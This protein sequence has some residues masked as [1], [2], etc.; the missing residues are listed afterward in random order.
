MHRRNFLLGLPALGTALVYGGTSDGSRSVRIKVDIGR[1][2]GTIPADFMG[3][4]YEISSVAR[5]GL[6]SAENHTYV[7]LVRTL[8]PRGVIRVGGNTSDYSSFDANGQAVSAPKNTVVNE[9]NLRE[10]GAFLEATGWKLIWGLNLG[11]G[12]E[13]EAIEEAQAVSAAVKRKLLAFEIGNE[14][15]LFDRRSAHREQELSL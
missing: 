2:L 3:L 10:L 12:S 11:G 6:L 1:S 14:P 13:A 9:A 15:D 4:G 8:G 5:S 7:Q